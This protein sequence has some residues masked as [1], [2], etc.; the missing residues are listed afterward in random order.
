MQ[1]ALQ[2]L[3]HELQAHGVTSRR[4]RALVDELYGVGLHPCR[5]HDA[6]PVGGQL[7]FRGCG[8]DQGG[9]AGV[10][11]LCQLR[12]K[13]LVLFHC[14][15]AL[16]L[17][18]G[19][20][21]LTRQGR[22]LVILLPP[23]AS[24]G[25]GVTLDFFEKAVVKELCNVVPLGVLEL[26]VFVPQLAKL[27]L[28]TGESEYSSA[29][30]VTIR[31]KR[32]RW[33]SAGTVCPGWAASQLL[34]SSSVMQAGVGSACCELRPL[35]VA[36]FSNA[37]VVGAS[38]GR[39]MYMRLVAGL[40]TSSASGAAAL[41]FRLLPLVFSLLSLDDRLATRLLR[42]CTISSLASTLLCAICLMAV[43]GCLCA[44]TQTGVL[45]P[46]CCCCISSSR[47]FK[48]FLGPRGWRLLDIFVCSFR[49]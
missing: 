32:L 6:C 34:N 13:L 21:R 41:A 45:L 14:R 20:A 9:G 37:S 38:A 10:D 46:V 15:V 49:L 36:A 48:T 12:G 26:L 4:L 11:C 29:C 1:G 22:L 7:L 43:R 23:V 24:H 18:V 25:A 47:S 27:V 35:P 2:P 33:C 44:F 19:R 39:P 30:L 40:G 17:Q 8:S 16:L 28:C 42:A 31:T 5:R 3:G